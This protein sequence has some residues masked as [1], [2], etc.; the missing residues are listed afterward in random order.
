MIR[1]AFQLGIAVGGGLLIGLAWLLMFPVFLVAA[2]AF[3][4]KPFLHNG[5]TL[6]RI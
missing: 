5:P 1:N 2:L 4:P 6:S 3:I